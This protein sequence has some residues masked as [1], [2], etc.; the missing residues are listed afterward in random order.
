MIFTHTPPRAMS[1]NGRIAIF[2]LIGLLPLG[3]VWSQQP[4]PVAPE[5]RRE[6]VDPPQPGVRTIVG[7]TLTLSQDALGNKSQVPATGP[8]TSPVA[9]IDPATIPQEQLMILRSISTVQGGGYVAEL[10]NVAT[11]Q[12]RGFEGSGRFINGDIK[13]V[14]AQGVL[15][16]KGGVA[17]PVLI[18]PGM[19]L[20]GTAIGSVEAYRLR[21]L[22]SSAPLP[23]SRRGGRG[24]AS[25]G[26]M[27]NPEAQQYWAGMQG[28]LQ[29]AAV[30][31]PDKAVVMALLEALA[32]PSQ[33]VSE[34]AQQ[35]LA[36]FGRD[37]LPIYIEATSSPTS[38]TRVG[39]LRAIRG[40]LELN[41]PY[42]A[43][44]GG[45]FGGGAGGFGRG[46]QAQFSNSNQGRRGRG[47]RGMSQYGNEIQAQVAPIAVK[48]LSDPEAEVRQS[49]ADVLPLLID[50]PDAAIPAMAKLLDSEET[51]LRV[52]GLTGLATVV[53]YRGANPVVPHLPAISKR[54]G[55]KVSECRLYAVN[56]LGN[57]GPAARSAVPELLTALKDT[58]AGIRAAAATALGQIQAPPPAVE[59]NSIDAAV[60]PVPRDAPGGQ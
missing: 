46:G 30:T 15:F 20:E 4:Q 9:A 43:I 5:G 49:A 51:N 55:D 37:A 52:A 6:L 22:G 24:G 42:R 41:V 8:A 47:G 36:G 28:A 53:R 25:R 26:G 32:D 16:A 60:N 44:A 50:Q 17:E 29:P 39:S 3:P 2:G 34:N 48:A 1:W 12:M 54:L 13:S 18:S 27:S 31:P 59:P 14:T 7:G 38:A 10:L 56:L 58:E 21:L 19:N 23:A 33:A 35:A 57:C 45:Y 11:G 40:V